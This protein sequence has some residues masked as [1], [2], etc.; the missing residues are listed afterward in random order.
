MFKNKIVY[1]DLN[2]SEIKLKKEVKATAT[3]NRKRQLSCEN[4]SCEVKL[5]KL[6]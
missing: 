6:S 5:A 2:R 3:A 1:L 4:I